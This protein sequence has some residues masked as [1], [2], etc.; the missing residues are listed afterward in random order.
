MPMI[1]RYKEVIRLPL[2]YKIDVMAALKAAGYTTYRIRK[3]KLLA[4]STLQS[5]RDSKPISWENIAT[6]CGMLDCQPGDIME[7][8][9]DAINN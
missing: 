9:P 8:V 2:I 7:Y 6:I 4:E 3:D 1:A 5:L